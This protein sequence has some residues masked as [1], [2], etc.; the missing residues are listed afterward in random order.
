MKM[1]TVYRNRQVSKDHQVHILNEVHQI[2]S[3]R[4][5]RHTHQIHCVHQV[6][7]VHQVTRSITPTMSNQAAKPA[8]GP[9]HGLIP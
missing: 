5:E 9:D 4:R 8:R 2:H 1:V 3:G 7:K 6:Q